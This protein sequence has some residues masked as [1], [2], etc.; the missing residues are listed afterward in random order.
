MSST[1]KESL[2]NKD[3]A[4]ATPP[5]RFKGDAHAVVAMIFRPLSKPAKST[6]AA[7]AATEQEDERLEDVPLPVTILPK[8]QCEEDAHAEKLAPD[9]IQFAYDQNYWTKLNHLLSNCEIFYI[10]RST[11]L[12]DRWSGQVGFPGGRKKPNEADVE[13]AAREVHEEV[14]LELP[15]L[16]L[17]GDASLTPDASA[18]TFLGRLNDRVITQNNRKLVVLS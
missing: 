16:R 18:Y 1:T 9:P 2:T 12:R 7:D 11:N 13:A 17:K 15:F 4:G 10:L 5:K 3:V 6:T 8:E 14:G